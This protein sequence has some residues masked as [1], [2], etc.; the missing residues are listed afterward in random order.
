VVLWSRGEQS[1]GADLCERKAS[2][3]EMHSQ[4]Q[5]IHFMPKDYKE[6]GLDIIK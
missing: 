2:G 6:F 5:I 4:L 1:V 3:R